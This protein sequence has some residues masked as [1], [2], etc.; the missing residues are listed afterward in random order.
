M[1]I[2]II[3]NNE[4]VASAEKEKEVYLVFQEEYEEGD[5]IVFT[6]EKEGFV[7]LQFD[8]V[9]GRATVY[10]NGKPFAMNIPFGQK[11]DCYQESVFKPCPE[12][13]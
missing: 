4:A 5:R 1:K 8:A 12:P 13:L 9:L 7:T 6:P 3:R 11:H 10:S 2:E